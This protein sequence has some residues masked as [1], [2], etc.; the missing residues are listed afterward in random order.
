MYS[1]LQRRLAAGQKVVTGEV[2]PPK[3]AARAQLEALARNLAP[4]VDA[5]NLTD[6][7]RGVAR[8]S[9]LGAG[10]D[11]PTRLLRDKAIAQ[12]AVASASFPTTTFAS[13][14]V[15]GADDDLQAAT[16]ALARLPLFPLSGGGRGTFEPAWVEDVVTAIEAELTRAAQPGPR[17]VELAGPERLRGRQVARLGLRAAAARR[18]VVPASPSWVASS[19]RLLGGSDG[20]PKAWDPEA[21][22]GAE[23]TSVDG[24]AGFRELGISPLSF[25]EVLGLA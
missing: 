8:M 7:Q 22:L 6:N 18:L 11:A 19:L 13:S 4:V 21:F 20:L 23:M 25:T 1:G 5:I 16:A 17:R 9:A 2:A 3:G 14:L 15:A 24:V 12:D 10:F